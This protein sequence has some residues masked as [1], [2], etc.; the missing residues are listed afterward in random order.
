MKKITW[1]L[2]VLL[3]I[4]YYRSFGQ[5]PGNADR[6]AGVYQIQDKAKK[7]HIQ[8][9]DT[10][11]VAK[12]ITSDDADDV[13]EILIG[14]IKFNGQDWTGLFT[15]FGKSFPVTLSFIDDQHLRFDVKGHE[16]TLVRI[17]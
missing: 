4:L 1:L 6:I 17:K 10:I 7:V 15:K 16:R 14:D 8:K 3:T 2:I 9:K 13:G 12:V 5:Q 11:Y